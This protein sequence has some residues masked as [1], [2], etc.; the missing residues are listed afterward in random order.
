MA[1][2]KSGKAGDTYKYQVKMVKPREKARDTYIYQVKI[3]DRV[4]HM[5]VTTDLKRREA[6]HQKDFPGSRVKQIGRK[7]TREEALRWERAEIEKV[8]IEP[9]E[10]RKLSPN[11]R[12][13]LLEYKEKILRI[14]DERV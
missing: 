8:K 11:T 9:E 10:L 2:Y 6:Q 4:V 14:L 3:G 13:K 5:G 1:T 12:S 7:S